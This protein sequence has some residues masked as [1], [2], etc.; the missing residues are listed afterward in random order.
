MLD[1][2]TNGEIDVIVNTPIGKQGAVD[3]SYIRKA[4]IKNRIA[5]YD[6]HGRRKGFRRG[7]PRG[8]GRQNRCPFAAGIPQRNYRAVI[9]L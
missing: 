5:L 7:D 8:A 3:D 9:L 6:H 2:I 1:L 4:A